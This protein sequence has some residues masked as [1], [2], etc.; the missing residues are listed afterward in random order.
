MSKFGHGQIL[1]V[2]RWTAAQS[3]DRRPSD[4]FRPT[5]QRSAW[6]SFS[7]FADQSPPGQSLPISPLPIG[8][9]FISPFSLS[10][11]IFFPSPQFKDIFPVS[12][13]IDLHQSGELAR[14]PSQ[15]SKAP[16]HFS[17][18][19]SPISL[20]CILYLKFCLLKLPPLTLAHMKKNNR[21]L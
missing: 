13:F 21:Q 17:K 9:P 18:V 4:S 7:L 6:W 19:F 2:I 11:R 3:S 14:A 12:C 1:E 10:T 15:V 16:S 20:L 8:P 5:Q